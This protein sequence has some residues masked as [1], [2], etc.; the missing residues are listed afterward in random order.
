MDVDEG[1]KSKMMITALAWVK[2]GYAKAVTDEMNMME[3]YE[4]A[5]ESTH[6]ESNQEEAEGEDQ[7][8][9]KNYDNEDNI[10]IFAEDYDGKGDKDDGEEDMEMDEQK[11]PLEIDDNEEEKED[12]TIHKSDALIVTAAAEQDYSNLEVY[13]YE[14]ENS[15][16]FVHHEIMLNAYP[17]CL[18]W[19]KYAPGSEA[20]SGKGNYIAVGTFSPS[21]E[22]WNLDIIDA[23]AP[24]IT[25]GGATQSAANV[26]LG[27]MTNKNKKKYFKE[28]S[29]V[30]AVLSLSA[31]PTE[32]NCLASASADKTIKIWDLST[33]KWVRTIKNH[34][35]KVQVLEWHPT[36]PDSILSAGFDGKGVVWNT[37]N[38]NEKIY[39]QFNNTEIESGCWH[40][41]Q[42][43]TCFFSFEDGSIKAFDTKNPETPILDF[44][45]HEQQCTSIALTKANENVLVSVSVDETIKVWDLGQIN[46]GKPA[47][48]QSKNMK[49]GG[50]FTWKFYEDSPWILASGGMKGELGIWDLENSEAIVKNFQ[51]QEALDKLKQQEKEAGIEG[52]I[53][54]EPVNDD[55]NSDSDGMDQDED[56]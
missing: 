47:L 1:I 43:F 50:L 8:D 55:S 5:K 51:G 42:E 10:P 26:N 48:I 35:D 20:A 11:F 41:T 53:S 16:L 27:A 24:E 6:Q 31:H 39:L 56:E 13:L 23:V 37:K 12:L 38:P 15:N 44:Q 7:F 46:D 33:G 2:R 4:E 30:D 3:K 9:M 40:P 19:L 29:H 36:D 34:K 18:E 25:L 49:I 45:A 21:I 28:N 17:L 52:R 32:V 54:P 22:I 14:E